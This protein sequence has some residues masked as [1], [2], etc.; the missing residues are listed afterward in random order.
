MSLR[1]G[2]IYKIENL[3]NSKVYIGQ[4]LD[5]PEKRWSRHISEINNYVNFYPLYMDMREYGVNSFS[6]QILESDISEDML[7]AKEIYYI[8]K[9][10]SFYQD[11]GYNLTR[12]GQISK[13]SKLTELQV[14]S[15]IDRIKNGE[16]FRDLANEFDVN[17]STISDINCGDTWHFDSY[18]YPIRKQLNPKKNYSESEA[19]EIRIQLQAGCNLTSV[20]KLH[21]TSVQTIRRINIGELYRD[22]SLVYPLYDTKQGHSKHLD[23]K[24]LLI[25]IE[26][27]LNSDFNYNQIS[28][29][30]NEKYGVYIDRHTI[31]GINN[32]SCY[33]TRLEEFGYE[34]FPIR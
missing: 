8:S 26:Y 3:I 7:D 13:S 17:Y 25:I 10:K 31:S 24:Y 21:N 32:G 19:E 28:K 14:L 1:V 33:K 27:L 30:I 12:G 29:D 4:T 16:S 15:I 9:Y 18:T 22:D 2:S 23:D 34:Y 6:F 11:G 5:K 20:A